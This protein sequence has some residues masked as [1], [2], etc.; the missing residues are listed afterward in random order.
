MSG[1]TAIAKPAEDAN[2]AYDTIGVVVWF[3]AIKGYGFA[4]EEDT[5][6]S[7][8]IHQTNIIAD[9]FR[10]LDEGDRF[11]CSAVMTEKGLNCLQ[12][13]KLEPCVS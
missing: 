6:K 4:K 7:L 2:G 10:F 11:E 13:K 12:V 9:G 3:D 1:H 5:G 8:F